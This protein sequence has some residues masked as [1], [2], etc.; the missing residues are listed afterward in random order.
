MCVGGGWGGGV[1]GCMCVCVCGG[2]VAVCVCVGGS[3]GNFFSAV[4]YMNSPFFPT[5]S[6]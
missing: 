5:K 6:I 1:G 4:W 3:V 2:G